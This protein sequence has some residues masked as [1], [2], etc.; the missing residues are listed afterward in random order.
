MAYS[1]TWRIN[2]RPFKIDPC[3]LEVELFYDLY[4]QVSSSF[5]AGSSLD[6]HDW[7]AKVQALLLLGLIIKQRSTRWQTVSLYAAWNANDSSQ[8]SYHNG[9]CHGPGLACAVISMSQFN[10]L[11]AL[12]QSTPR[13]C[14][15]ISISYRELVGV[16]GAIRIG[17]YRL[18]P[19]ISKHPLQQTKQEARIVCCFFGYNF[20]SLHLC[21][22]PTKLLI[23]L[24]C[25][26]SVYSS[27]RRWRSGNKGWT[28]TITFN[29]NDRLL[30]A[31]KAVVLACS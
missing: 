26:R 25:Y 4:N 18:T 28:T 1:W 20:F 14:T 3:A 17:F 30:S 27:M 2:L 5:T 6:I 31:V 23:C 10:K 22:T 7:Y 21:L 9:G 13:V 16:S 15:V 19:F 29:N 12:C 24:H 8:K 11:E